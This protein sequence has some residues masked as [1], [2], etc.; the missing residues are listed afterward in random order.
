MANKKQAVLNEEAEGKS[1]MEIL[2]MGRGSTVFKRNEYADYSYPTGIPIIDYA[3][4]YEISVKD[5]DGKLIKKRLC[6]GLQAGT[7]NVVSGMTQ[8]FKTTIMIQIIANIAYK[9]EGNIRHYD[10]EQ[11][12]VFERIKQLSK[13]PEAWFEGEHPLYSYHWGAIGFDTIQKDIT[14]IYENKMRYKDILLKDTGEVDSHNRPVKMMPPT[15]MFLDSLQ[16][17]ITEQARYDVNNKEFDGDPELRSN[18]AGAQNAKTVRGF[19]TDILP[20]LKEANIMFIAIAHKTSNMG[21]GTFSPPKKQFTY[22]SVNERISG[23]SAVEFNASAVISLSGVNASDAIFTKETDGFNGN[24]TLFEPTKCSTNESGNKRTGRGFELVIDRDK[25]G[26]DNVRSLILF[27]K[28]KNRL[29]GNSANYKVLDKNGEEITNR[30][31]WRNCY[32][33]FKNDPDSYRVFMQT[34]REELEA[35]VSKSDEN[36]AGTINPLDLS[37]FCVISEANIEEGVHLILNAC[38][39]A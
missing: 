32:E 9:F 37:Q 35:Y 12:S 1:L 33:D 3:L 7:F 5:D 20:M 17:V 13:L 6:L 39:C 21:Q 22:A 38:C 15:I 27:L 2:S 31:S 30:F 19:L 29:K 36:A 10:T 23:G 8:A 34:C 16:D 4:G 14:T 26:V 24:K 25:N 28:S 18:M 11:R